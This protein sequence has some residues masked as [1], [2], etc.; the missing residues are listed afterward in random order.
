VPS[1]DFRGISQSL[2]A[3]SMKIP[4][5]GYDRFLPN[6][7]QY[8]VPFGATYPVATDSVGSEPFSRWLPF[9]VP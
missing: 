9:Q 5:L 3:N 4:R 7:F 1:E 6:L 2:K 8:I